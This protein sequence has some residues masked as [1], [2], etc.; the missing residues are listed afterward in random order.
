M[1]RSYIKR[2]GHVALQVKDLD[3]SLKFYESLGLTKKWSGDDDWAQVAIG[4]ED[5][6]LIRKQGALHPPHVGFRVEDRVGLQNLHKD[7]VDRGIYV[8]AIKLHRDATESFYFRD[9]DGNWLEALWDP[10][11]EK[12]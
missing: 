1:K 3:R 9:P 6:S 2:M 5:L 4:S 11:E 10:S 12:E 7:L 8:E